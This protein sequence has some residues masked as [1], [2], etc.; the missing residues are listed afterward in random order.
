MITGKSVM[1]RTLTI[2]AL[3]VVATACNRS[4]EPARPTPAAHSPAPAHESVPVPPRPD[5]LAPP[6]DFAAIEEG[7]AASGATDA[8]AESP[9]PRVIEGHGM[10]V[11]VHDDGTVEVRGNDL[12]DASVVTVYESCEFARAAIPTL[13]RSLGADR[14]EAVVSAC[15]DFDPDAGAPRIA[16]GRRAPVRPV[17]R[18]V[19]RPA[20]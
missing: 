20:R 14:V 15:G 5:R 3:L 8:S 16:G 12:W 6:P 9:R 17:A 4:R 11:E 13:R 18:P 10:H 19:A 2:A 1:T 7:D